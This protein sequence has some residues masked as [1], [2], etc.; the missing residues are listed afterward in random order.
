MSESYMVAVCDIMGYSNLV[1]E[2]SL[3]ELVNYHLGN[4]V[5]VV[6]SSIPNSHENTIVP[7]E[8]ELLKTGAVGHVFFSDT[9]IIY[10]LADNRDG[11]KNVLDAVYRLLCIPMNTPYYRYRIGIAYGEMYVDIKQNIYVGKALV[12]AHDLEVLQEWSGASLMESAAN[13]FKNHYPENSM[14]VNYD[15]P[16]KGNATKRLSVVNWTLAN[17]KNVTGQENWMWR[18][19]KGQR[20]V[21][22]KDPKVELK[23]RNTEKFHRE[24]CVQCNA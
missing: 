24:M 8:V 7:T 2:H 5:N 18:A 16:I 23:I 19:E 12:E 10:S 21:R 17:H 11:R 9:I 15:V 22:Y 6:K 3:Q 4:I 1:R 14:I 13:M 20:V